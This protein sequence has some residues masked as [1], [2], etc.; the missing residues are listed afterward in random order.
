MVRTHIIVPILL[1]TGVAVFGDGL[2]HDEDALFCLPMVAGIVIHPDTQIGS[3]SPGENQP[4]SEAWTQSLITHRAAGPDRLMSVRI[5]DAWRG[6]GNRETQDAGSCH[7]MERYQRYLK[8][9][10]EYTVLDGGEHTHTHTI[11]GSYTSWT[12]R[13]K[14]SCCTCAIKSGYSWET[15]VLNRSTCSSSG[16]NCL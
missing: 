12:K 1:A 3:V 4:E 2:A 15:T 16:G 11:W 9:L 6:K 14:S 5:L 8:S 7:Y 10:V 13:M